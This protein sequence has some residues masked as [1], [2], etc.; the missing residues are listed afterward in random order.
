M[1]WPALQLYKHNKE[2]QISK[3]YSRSDA[4][5]RNQKSKYNKSP[6]FTDLHSMV[7][8]GEKVEAGREVS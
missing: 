2:L 1:P 6:E 3:R 5:K 4:T 8:E 7:Y